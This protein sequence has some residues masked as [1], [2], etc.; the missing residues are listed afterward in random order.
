MERENLIDE[1]LKGVLEKLD[2]IDRGESFSTCTGR[3]VD[4]KKPI[5]LITSDKEKIIVDEF[6]ENEFLK[7]NCHLATDK[8]EFDSSDICQGVILDLNNLELCKL[9]SGFCD[10]AKLMLIEDLIQSGKEIYLAKEGIDFLKYESH[11]PRNFIRMYKNKL[12]ILKSWKIKV[13][14]MAGIKNELEK[15]Y[16]SNLN[17]R[18]LV[19]DGRVLTKKFITQKDIEIACL[20]GQSQI[21]ISK[22]SKMTDVASEYAEKMNI[23]V[24]NF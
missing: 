13:L 23:K 5:L 7:A 1:I 21:L 6:L 12:D 22:Q 8:D 17:K 16:H 4:S 15:K 2:A 20:Q 19:Y 10:T 9:S 24:K 3:E 11:S 18:N 14:P